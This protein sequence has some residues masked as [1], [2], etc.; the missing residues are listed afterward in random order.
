[1]SEIKLTKA[2]FKKIESEWSNYKNTLYEIKLLEE[3]IHHPF[4]ESISVSGGKNSVRNISKDVEDK[5]IRLTTHKQLIYLKEVVNAIEV[6]YERLPKDKKKLVNVRYWSNRNYDW[7]GIA[8][9]CNV[10]RRQALRWRDDIV[11]ATANLLGWR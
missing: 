6:V 3:S 9:K 8:N 7:N 10:S 11:F 4:Q 2:T 1:M 5:A